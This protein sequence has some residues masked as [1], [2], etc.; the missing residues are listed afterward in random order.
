MVNWRQARGSPPEITFA[1][2]EGKSVRCSAAQYVHS[3]AA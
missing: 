1:L 2:A 3:F